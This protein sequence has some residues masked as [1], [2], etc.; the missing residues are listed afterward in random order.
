MKWIDYLTRGIA[1]II[2]AQTL[3]FKFSA[4]PES[5]YIFSAIGVEPWG[6]IFSGIVE[7]IV[8]VLLILPGTSA[9]G[10]LLGAITMFGA[11][12][13]H[14]LKLGIVVKDDAGLLFM[15]ASVTFLCCGY[16]LWHHRHS[17]QRLRRFTER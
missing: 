17:L 10:A 4:A 9:V 1:V 7:L 2:L 3:Y 11:I 8:C 6:R 5:V 14:I 12:A 13:A 15:M 16:S